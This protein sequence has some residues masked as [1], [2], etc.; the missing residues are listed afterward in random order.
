[1]LHPGA[2]V[3][4]STKLGPNAVENGFPKETH[5]MRGAADG[6]VGGHVGFFSSAL[7]LG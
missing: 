7:G 3:A 6:H 4:S 2:G 1:M 5:R